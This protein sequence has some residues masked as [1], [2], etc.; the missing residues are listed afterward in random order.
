MSIKIKNPVTRCSR[1]PRNFGDS[2]GAEQPD[3][4]FR[5]F[6]CEMERTVAATNHGRPMMEHTPSI[7]ATIIKSR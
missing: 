6:T 7:I 5:L 2:P 1:M 4:T 3:S